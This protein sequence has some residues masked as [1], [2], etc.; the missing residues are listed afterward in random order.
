[1]DSI[2]I[3]LYGITLAIHQGSEKK[4]RREKGLDDYAGLAWGEFSKQ[5]LVSQ[6]ELKRGFVGTCL[7]TH[8]KP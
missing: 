7:V 1:M 8:P 5:C 3:D 4:V 2:S 6:T